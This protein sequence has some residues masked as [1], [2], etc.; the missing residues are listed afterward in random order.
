MDTAQASLRSQGFVILKDLVPQ[1]I[2]ESLYQTLLNLLAKYHRQLDRGVLAQLREENDWSSQLLSDVLIKFRAEKPELFGI[3]YDTIQL[4]IPIQQLT[5][6][7]EVTDRVAAIFGEESE[8]LS[9]TGPMLRMDPPNDNRNSLDWHQD[10][11]Y[12]QQNLSGDHGVVLWM[13]MHA[14]NASHGAIVVC[15]G[16]HKLSKIE[17]K[18]SGGSNDLESEQ[19]RIPQNVIE[20]FEHFQVEANAGDVVVFTMDLIHRSG[21]NSSG[22]IRFV[23]GIRYHKMMPDDF[24]PGKLMYQENTRVGR[25]QDY[26]RRQ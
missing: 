21:V 2:R 23:S 5:C 14:V 19:Y 13:P 22:K 18:K 6:A 1:S 25:M 16:S 8:S 12:Y 26:L 10:S 3:L 4:S 17:T 11:A 20:Q 9:A 15:P 7:R 24:L